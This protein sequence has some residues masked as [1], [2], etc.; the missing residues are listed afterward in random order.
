MLIPFLQPV[1]A[2]K[3]DAIWVACADNLLP[4]RSQ[5]NSVT[6]ILL[7]LSAS[8]ADGLSDMWLCQLL[9]VLCVYIRIIRK[10]KCVTLVPANEADSTGVLLQGVHP[11]PAVSGVMVLSVDVC[12]AGSRL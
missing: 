4:H 6:W 5:F 12:F 3:L 1:Q 11:C 9:L 7:V 2:H 10:P 8:V